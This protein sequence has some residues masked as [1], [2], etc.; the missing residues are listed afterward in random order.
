[1]DCAGGLAFGRLVEEGDGGVGLEEE[2]V[3]G[4]GWR[5]YVGQVL[6]VGYEDLGVFMAQYMIR[7]QRSRVDVIYSGVLPHSYLMKLLT[8]LL[9]Q[10]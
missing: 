10:V 3:V 4:G 2:V 9:L 5:Y 7:V 6:V 1:M 8:V